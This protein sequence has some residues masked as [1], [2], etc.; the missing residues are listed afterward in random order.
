MKTLVSMCSL[1]LLAVAVFTTLTGASAAQKSKSK[2]KAKAPAKIPA[3]VAP[4]SYTRE[5]KP[6]LDKYCVGCHNPDLKKGMLNLETYEEMMKGGASG[7]NFVVGKSAESLFYKALIGKD[8]PKMPPKN[9]IGP[10][11][12]EIELIKRW[13]DEGVKNDAVPVKPEEKKEPK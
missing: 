6:L 8:A 1:S 10:S 9:N 13:I 4:A 7:E 2:A 3:K 5:I 12:K 11:D